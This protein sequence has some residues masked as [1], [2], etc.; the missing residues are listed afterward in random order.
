MICLAVHLGKGKVNSFPLP[1][2][3]WLSAVAERR[4]SEQQTTAL[5]CEL[6][7]CLVQKQHRTQVC[8]CFVN[9]Q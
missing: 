7:S 3:Y 4:E 2:C 1:S 5:L 8:A 9:W 6:H